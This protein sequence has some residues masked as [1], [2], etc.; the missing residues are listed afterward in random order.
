[1]RNILQRVVGVRRAWPGRRAGSFVLTKYDADLGAQE[2][3]EGK[4]ACEAV[5][6]WRKRPVCKQ[7]ASARNPHFISASVL[8]EA[9]V[10]EMCG[11]GSEQWPKGNYSSL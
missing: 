1:M 5:K 9:I 3:K 4:G 10:F 7:G 11:E 2:R 8:T 6:V